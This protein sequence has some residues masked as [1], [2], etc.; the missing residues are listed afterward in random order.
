MTLATAFV[1]IYYAFPVAD[2]FLRASSIQT[3]PWYRE[4]GFIYF[5]GW[6]GRW[7]ANGLELL[8]G[9]GIDLMRWYPVVLGALVPF[10]ALG[11]IVF[12]RMLLG[13]TVR[14][15]QVLVLTAATMAVLWA[16]MPSPGETYYW[17]CGGIEYYLNISLSMLLIGGLVLGRWEEMSGWR[18]VAW[19]AG[20]SLLAFLVTGMHEL[21]A[22][23]FCMVLVTGTA[24][25]LKIRRSTHQV[26]AWLVVSLS[27]LLGL[28]VVAA[29]PGNYLRREWFAKEYAIQ[30]RSLIH[31][32]ELAW[33]QAWQVLPCWVLD[34][35]LLAATLV[36]VLT[37]SLARARAGWPRWGGISPK[38]VVTALWLL[39]VA[40]MF[41][42]PSY[43]MH[44]P[45]P[46]Q[47]LNAT[48]TVFVLGWITAVVVWTRSQAESEGTT[49][50]SQEP[51]G[52]RFARSAA[53]AVLGLSLLVTGNTRNGII[54]LRNRVPQNWNRMNHWRDHLIREAMRR[55]ATQVELPIR[56][57]AATYLTNCPRMYF[58]CD[59]TE[60]PTFWV[61]GYLAWY[62]GVNSIRRVP[63]AAGMASRLEL[64]QEMVG[65]KPDRTPIRK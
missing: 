40:G 36:I 50:K 29:A 46:K 34:V 35:R 39:I 24:I 21:I 28:A 49:A 60:E 23:M 3:R 2:D 41:F 14:R 5:H 1:L 53:L 37:P 12:W 64:R 44:M 22:L 6:S 4:V 63:Q 61:N 51:I 45:M 9:R 16:S 33:G 20:L 18:A 47:V 54:G 43:L 55:G 10:Q 17:M 15:L 38:L 7:V 19:T 30:D 8:I 27:A 42:C 65:L 13:G 11:L 56:D 62:Y 58:F 59:I 31:A 26:W 52:P 48:Y 25:S 57:F 32:L